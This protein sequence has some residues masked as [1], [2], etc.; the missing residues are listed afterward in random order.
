MD[1]G[2]LNANESREF[3]D[4]LRVKFSLTNA[5]NLEANGKIEWGHNLIY[6]TIIRECAEKVEDRTRLTPC[7]QLEPPTSMWQDL[8]RPSLVTGSMLAEESLIAY[9]F[10][11]HLSNS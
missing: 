8:C 5:S 2:E 11:H 4:K 9:T 10:A 6:K 7:G 3:F 1:G